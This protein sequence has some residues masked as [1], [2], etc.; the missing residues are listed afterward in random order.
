MLA[1]CVRSPTSNHTGAAPFGFGI[2]SV[3]YKTTVEGGD[4][5]ARTPSYYF[6]KSWTLPTPV[7]GTQYVFTCLFCE[8]RVARLLSC[9]SFRRP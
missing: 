3:A 4:A 1:V 5:A 9:F 7:V 2:L 8:S 6:R